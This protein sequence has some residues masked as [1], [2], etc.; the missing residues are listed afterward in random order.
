MY[1]QSRPKKGAAQQRWLHATLVRMN[2]DTWKSQTRIIWTGVQVEGQA[3]A[4]RKKDA[5]AK[6]RASRGSST[7]GDRAAP[8]TSTPAKHK[9]TEESE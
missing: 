3:K 2:G 9:R 8:S 5:E 1:S 6:K 7:T 4:K